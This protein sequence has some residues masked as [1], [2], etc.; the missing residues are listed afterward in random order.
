MDKMKDSGIFKNID[1][2][3]VPRMVIEHP[4]KGNSYLLFSFNGKEELE[5]SAISI[6]DF[7]ATISHYWFITKLNQKDIETDEN[8]TTGHTAVIE[9]ATENPHTTEFEKL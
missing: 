3:A 6:S 2:I 4:K 8:N 5:A 9:P 1:L 7:F